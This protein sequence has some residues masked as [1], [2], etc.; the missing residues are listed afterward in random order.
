MKFEDPKA[1]AVFE[2]YL[3]RHADE[4]A[5]MKE[6]GPRMFDNRDELLLPVGEDA[7]WFL[8]ALIMARKPK[9]I[10]ELGT[11]YG[12]STLFLADAANK[13]GG[14]VITMELEDYKQQYA[15][16]KLAEAGLDGVVDWRC[17]DAVALIEEDNGPFDF[18]LLDIWKELYQPSFDAFYP[19]LSEE[20]VICS[21]NMIDPASARPSVRIYREAVR[22]KPDLQTALLPVGQ[23][24]EIS[25]KWSAGNA[26]L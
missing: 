5:R 2:G 13:V 8:H 14:T 12:Y 16:E 15:R 19:K 3:A 7:A 1:Q 24:I 23:G 22:A 17:G 26:K 4:Q 9:R 6:L 25:V 18:I 21:D 20:A 10:L 11:S